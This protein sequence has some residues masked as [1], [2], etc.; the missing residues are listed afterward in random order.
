M[1]AIATPLGFRFHAGAAAAL[2]A[3]SLAVG[4]RV[5]FSSWLNLRVGLAVRDAEVGRLAVAAPLAVALYR[6]AAV[7]P[8]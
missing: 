3:V 1:I 7:P 2:A 8:N 5:A 4:V 6:R